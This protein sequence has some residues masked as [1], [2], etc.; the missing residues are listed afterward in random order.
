MQILIIECPEQRFPTVACSD[1]SVPAPS[2]VVQYFDCHCRECGCPR[3]RAK[4]KK[5]R[6]VSCQKQC[7]CYLSYSANIWYPQC[8]VPD[9]LLGP[10]DSQGWE[11]PVFRELIARFLGIMCADA[12]GDKR[13]S[14]NWVLS[15]THTVCQA[16]YYIV[17]W[18]PRPPVG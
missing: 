17:P 6:E 3:L 5:E 14:W 8:P 7:P 13:C 2:R 11:A 18:D 15:L 4:V 12:V 1:W 10:R 9:C 16:H